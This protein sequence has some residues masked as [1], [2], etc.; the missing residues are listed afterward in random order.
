MLYLVRWPN[1]SCSLVRAGSE[2]EV[3]DIID[4]LDNPD[5]VKIFQYDGPVFIDFDLATDDVTPVHGV[6]RDDPKPLSDA[7]IKIGDVTRI[8]NHEMPRANIPDVDTGMEMYR[9]MAAKAFPALHKALF[10]RDGARTPTLR[11]VH[12]AVRKEAMMLVATAWRRRHLERSQDPIDQIAVRMGTSPDVVRSMAHDA[13][14]LE[15]DD[16]TPF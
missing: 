10:S 9:A 16:W 8:A 14:V 7:N 6:D 4:E 3:L 2:R 5:G 1:L 13:G 12:N 15:D 11:T